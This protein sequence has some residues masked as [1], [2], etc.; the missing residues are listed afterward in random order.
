GER[1]YL[2]VNTVQTHRRH[3]MEKLDLHDR[4][5]LVRYAH[6]VGLLQPPGT[7]TSSPVAE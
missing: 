6:R 3:I 5:Q 4:S 1:L 7:T 2:S